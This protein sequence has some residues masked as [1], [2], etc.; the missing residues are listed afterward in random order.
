[1]SAVSPSAF[2]MF[3]SALA[4]SSALI[5]AVSPDMAASDS[6]NAPKSFFALTSAPATIRRFT[7]SVSRL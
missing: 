1:M 2:A 6:G 7:R 4:S 5:N 3:A